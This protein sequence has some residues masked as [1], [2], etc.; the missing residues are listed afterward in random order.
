MPTCRILL[1]G[2][3]G[4]LGAHTAVELIEAGFDVLIAD[5]LS[6]AHLEVLDGI[7]RIT[8]IR[9]AFER[10]DLRDAVV[11]RELLRRY[12]VDG[13]IHLAAHKSAGE[14]VLKPLAYY[15]NNV[16]ALVSLLGEFLRRGMDR[17]VFS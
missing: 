6:N 16:T 9:P 7:E 13:C 3:L 8:G 11:V 1:T 17:L 2:G 10:L 15:D 12:P 4:Y 5:N 14:S